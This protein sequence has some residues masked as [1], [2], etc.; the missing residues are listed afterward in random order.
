M[1]DQ[2]CESITLKY[3]FVSYDGKIKKRDLMYDQLFV[4][5]FK[6]IKVSG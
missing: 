2:D 4:H 3:E 6:Y 5:I 1:A